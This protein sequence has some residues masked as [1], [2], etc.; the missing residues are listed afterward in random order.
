MTIMPPS[1]FQRAVHTTKDAAMT[2]LIVFLVVIIVFVVS[3]VE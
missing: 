2:L 1:H 3:P